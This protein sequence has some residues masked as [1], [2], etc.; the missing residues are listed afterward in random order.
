MVA[1]V[2]KRRNKYPMTRANA[3]QGSRTTGD[4][5]SIFSG[6]TRASLIACPRVF[7]LASLD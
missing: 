2:E 5:R 6:R 3:K 7:F 1:I 4:R